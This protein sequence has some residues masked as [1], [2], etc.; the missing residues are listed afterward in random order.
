MVNPVAAVRARC[1]PD[2]FASISVDSTSHRY[3]ATSFLVAAFDRRCI[4]GT[5]ARVTTTLV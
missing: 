5:S 2:F 4:T 1:N 3:H